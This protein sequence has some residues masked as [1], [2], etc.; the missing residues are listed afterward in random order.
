MGGG[1]REPHVMEDKVLIGASRGRN[2][3][4]SSD[5]TTGAPTEQRL[6]INEN[7]TSNTLTSVQ[8]DNYVVEIGGKNG[9]KK[10]ADT[11]EVLSELRKEI[12]TEEVEEWGLRVLNTLQQTEVLRQEMYGRSVH[13]ETEETRRG[14]ELV[15]G[16]REG[17]ELKEFREM[18]EMWSNREYRHTPQGRELEKQF[19][20]KLG[21]FV[22]EL[23]YSGTQTEKSLQ[24]LRETTQGIRVLQQA[25]LKIQEIWRPSLYEEQNVTIRKL[26]PLETWR[27]QSFT[28]EQFQ[29]AQEDGLSNTQLYKQAGNA[30]TVNV[31]IE[32]A[33]KIKDLDKGID[34]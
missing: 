7:G 20:R 34:L 28:D 29:K 25:L 27:L 33:K 19:I 14:S 6:E 31:I 8:K 24:D 32:L 30:V 18:R 5:R 17:E 11:L 10:E 13:K 21:G 9:K 22:Q 26:T 3:A 2:P 1:G 23:S 4:N 15:R 16:S 12:G